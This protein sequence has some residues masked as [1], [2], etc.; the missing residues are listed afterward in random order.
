LTIVPK[1]KLPK[2]VAQVENCAVCQQYATPHLKNPKAPPDQ[3]NPIVH[4]TLNTGEPGLDGPGDSLAIQ[5]GAHKS[6]HGAFAAAAGTTLYFVGAVHPWMQGRIVVT[7]WRVP[8]VGG[9]V[10]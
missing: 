7:S 9:R 6:N 2:T 10:R 3:N 4:W 8:E 5:P 1:A